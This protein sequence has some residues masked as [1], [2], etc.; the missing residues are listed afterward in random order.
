MYCMFVCANSKS[1][2]L[3]HKISFKT[4][5]FK[6]CQYLELIS[7]TPIFHFV[8]LYVKKINNFQ[9]NCSD[10]MMKCFEMICLQ[11]MVMYTI[12]KIMKSRFVKRKIEKPSYPYLISRTV[13]Y[14]F[15]FFATNAQDVAR[16]NQPDLMLFAPHNP[17]I[18]KICQN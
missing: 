11:K 16:S 12:L 2:N 13:H 14:F 17:D 3:L 1:F 10:S 5:C 9:P 18:T 15:L 7:L 6:S 4:G 8:L